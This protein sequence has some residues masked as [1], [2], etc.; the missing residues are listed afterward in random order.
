MRASDRGEGA[1][2]YIAVLLLVAVVVAAVAVSG[3]GGR[4]SGGIGS[5]VCQVAS[6]AGCGGGRPA[7]ADAAGPRKAPAQGPGPQE[8]P[9]DG[10]CYDWLDW[11]CGLTDGIRR[12]TVNAVKDVWDGATFVTC[13]VHICSHQGF[14]DNWSGLKNLVTDPVGSGKAIWEESTEPIR[15]DWTGGHKMRAAGLTVP[16]ILGRVFGSKGLGS[17]GRLPHGRRVPRLDRKAF[18]DLTDGVESRV[19]D[20]DAATLR[21][22]VGAAEE[23][24]RKAEEDLAKAREAAKDKDLLDEAHR[25]ENAEWY[26]NRLKSDI[27]LRKALLTVPGGQEATALLVKHRV[28]IEATHQRDR[29]VIYQKEH[30][31]LHHP[32]LKIDNFHGHAGPLS[33]EQARRIAPLIVAELKDV[34]EHREFPGQGD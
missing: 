23:H 31:G 7:V 24:L 8:K 5:A 25:V 30:A 27:L 1:A 9:D 11:A 14:K 15:D 4:V 28:S 34:D 6:G 19:F 21:G 10:N 2:S 26:V 22:D 18:V 16:T 13:L 20:G 3:L 29:M 33:E 17:L 32:Y 12:G